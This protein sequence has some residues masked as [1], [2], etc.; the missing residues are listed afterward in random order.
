L[1]SRR[2]RS[3]RPAAVWTTVKRSTTWPLASTTATAWS[4]RAQSTPGRPVARPGG[5]KD[6]LRR[7][8]HV[9][10]LAADP[11]GEAP[12]WLRILLD[13]V[14]MFGKGSEKPGASGAG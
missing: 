8:L 6:V 7:M 11:S 14:R 3:R 10:L 5:R 2:T 9:S 1:P 12:Y 13:S 4:S